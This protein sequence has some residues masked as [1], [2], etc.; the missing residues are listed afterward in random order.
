MDHIVG[1]T[2]AVRQLQRAA[3]AD[4]PAHAYLFTGP[5]AIGKRTLA[6]AF[7]QSL[8]CTGDAPPC[9]DCRACRLIAAGH[10]ADVQ[11][12]EADESTVK[13]DQI[14]ALQ[15]EASLAPIEARWRIFLLP[16]VERATHAAANSLLKTLEEPPRHVVLLLTAVD[17][18]ALLPTVVSRC[19]VV[20]L[21]PLPA[22]EVQ[23]ALETRW[24]V[25]AERA[26]LLARLSGG[27]IGWTIAALED[28]AI[29]ERRQAEL[30]TIATITRAGRVE[31]LRLAAEMSQNE[32][33]LDESL[34]LWLS[35]WRDLLVL[36]A[37]VAD[38]V[39]NADYLPV[40]KR[41][42]SALPL[43]EIFRTVRAIGDAIRQID[44]NVNKLLALEVL[45]LNVPFAGQRV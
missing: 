9:G 1:H 44:A 8:N 17:T 33:H 6:L 22:D 41:E 35:W 4:Q 45:L 25:D 10:H 32:A 5:P 28:S 12:I 24:G 36:R 30:E 18:A 7:A 38:A 3:V 23:S 15:S 20:P 16:N 39:I 27:R 31:R 19:R 26:A 2:S 14:R 11:V 13:I 42:A 29:L 21:R 43:A 40:L 34:A 37:G